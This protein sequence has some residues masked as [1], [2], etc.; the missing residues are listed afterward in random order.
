M[1]SIITVRRALMCLKDDA[2]LEIRL[3][4]Q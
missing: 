2:S 4:A 3:K 1:R